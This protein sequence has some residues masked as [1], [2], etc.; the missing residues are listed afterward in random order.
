MMEKDSL[1]SPYKNKLEFYVIHI[2]NTDPKKKS[3]M[4]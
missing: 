3:E 1:F 2:M 4:Q